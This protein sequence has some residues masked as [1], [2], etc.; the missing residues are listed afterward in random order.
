MSASDLAAD[1]SPPGAPHDVKRVPASSTTRSP[2]RNRAWRGPTYYGRRQLKEAPFENWVVGGYIFLAGISGGASTVA[3][4][5]RFAAG[6]T[7]D[8]LMRRSRWLSLL[9]PT[10]GSALLV[11]DLHT[12][13]RFLNM[14]RVAKR[15]SPMSIGTWLLLGFTGGAMPAFGLQMLSSLLP[16][17]AWPRK[18]A[19]LFSV[20]A[21]LFGA[22]ISTYTAAL[23]ASTS[24]PLW[25]ASPR[26]LAIRFGASS[27]A[28][29][30]AALSIGEADPAIRRGLDTVA[31]LALLAELG[32][33]LVSHLR[34]RETGVDAALDGNWGKIETWGVNG[35]G[36]VLPLALH[37]AG[38]VGL[39]GTGTA[40][41]RLAAAA[42]IAGSGMLRL[43]VMEAGDVSARTPEISFR[44]AQPENLPSEPGV[45]GRWLRRLRP[46]R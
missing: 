37:A 31:S 20:P 23:L 25:A 4:A 32:G 28:T 13:Q 27:V 24:T 3:G 44:F 43:S 7:A 35:I 2:S 45:F 15:T 18:A 14:M 29:G 26:G 19:N 8:P 12:P 6:E 33:S 5:A 40:T 9:A 10:I 22:G 30:A 41:S 39:R 21:A 46:D 16:G 42:V 17:R 11:Y 38:A 1:A 34:Y 36:V